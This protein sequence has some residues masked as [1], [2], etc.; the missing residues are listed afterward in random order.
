M[1]CWYEIWLSWPC[2]PN[3]MNQRI[4]CCVFKVSEYITHFTILYQI[5]FEPAYVERVLITCEEW[6]HRRACVWVQS[7]S[8]RYSHT[9]YRKLLESSVKGMDV[10]PHLMCVHARLKDHKPHDAKVP[11]LVRWIVELPHDK[12]NKITVHPAKT[13]I[14]LGIRPVWSKSLLCTQWVAKGPS[15]LHADSEDSDQTGRMPRLIWVFAWRT[16]ILLVLSWG[17]SFFLFR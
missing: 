14:K 1:L 4:N 2:Q 5:L 6:R 10:W 7:R 16:V 15:F 3:Y 17:G 9:Q 12:T 11:F 8:L 13:Q